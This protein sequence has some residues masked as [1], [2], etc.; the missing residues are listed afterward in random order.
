[1]EIV[2]VSVYYKAPHGMSIVNLAAACP[3][4]ESWN[5]GFTINAAIKK[6]QLIHQ[7]LYR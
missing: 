3:T 1:M 5:L 6:L 7:L 4:G 2:R